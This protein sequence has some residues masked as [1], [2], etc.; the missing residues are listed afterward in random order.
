MRLIRLVIQL[1]LAVLLARLGTAAVA[2][3]T[4]GSTVSTASGATST[5]Q[6][7]KSTSAER[8]SASASTGTSGPTT[9]V[10]CQDDPNVN[11]E[12]L[13]PQCSDN[14][15]NDLTDKY[16]AL[17]CN[18]CGGPALSTCYDAADNCEAWNRN[19][20]CNNT[21]NPPEQKQKYCEKTCGFC[22]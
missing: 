13:K 2:S 12:K 1:V 6:T 19:G 14:R 4:T 10:D 9:F 11:C 8:T 20:F 17:T 18:R 7:A 22:T 15:Y 21:F 16:C 3:S 5:T